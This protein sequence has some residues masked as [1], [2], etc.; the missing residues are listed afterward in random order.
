MT[1]IK[2]LESNKSAD[3]LLAKNRKIEPSSKKNYTAKEVPHPQVVLALGFL[4][5]KPRLFNPSCQSTCMPY[6]YIS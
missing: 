6:K 3:T 2:L 5:T 4:K 1:C